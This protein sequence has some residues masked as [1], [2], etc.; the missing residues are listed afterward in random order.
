[1]WI[2]FPL[3]V[4]HG[5]L[6]VLRAC[7]GAAPGL[8]AFVACWPCCIALSCCGPA[9]WVAVASLACICH[10]TASC[11]VVS[12]LARS[13]ALSQ[14]TEIKPQ[15]GPLPRLDCGAGAVGFDIEANIRIGVW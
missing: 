12:W 9:L 14:V 1:M 6:F 4:A 7:A 13:V 5:C 8:A 10:C 3:F 11:A 2:D 15:L